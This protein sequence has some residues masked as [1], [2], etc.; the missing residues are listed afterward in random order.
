MKGS[1][2]IPISYLR[3]CLDLDPATGHLY[4]KERP[5]NHFPTEQHFV[6]SNRT[7]TGKRADLSTF[8]CNGYR[9]V[10][11]VYHG[12]AFGLIAHR[13]VFEIHNGHWPVFEI[14]HIDQD[15]TNNKPTNLRDVTHRV[16]LSNR[17]VRPVV[18]TKEAA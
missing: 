8:Q 11:I 17:R 16:N 4:W 9:R 3:E 6:F 5:R 15:R 7:K 2:L 1:S 14:D 18:L 13:V 10:R 12:R